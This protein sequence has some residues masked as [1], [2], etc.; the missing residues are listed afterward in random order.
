MGK[1]GTP[2]IEVTEYFMSV[3]F[4]IC[5]QADA[6][7]ALTVKEKSAWFGR[8]EGEGSITISQSELFGGL[9]K[10]GGLRGTAYYLPGGDS[11]VLPNNLAQKLGRA[12]GADCP[13]YRGLA[14]IFFYGSSP[15][16]FYWTANTPYLPGVW[17]KVERAPVGLNPDYALIPTGG[18][19][20]A[21]SVATKEELAEQSTTGETI[22]AASMTFTP[23]PETDYLFLWSADVQTNSTSSPCGLDVSIDGSSIFTNRPYN[24]Q[25]EVVSPIDYVTMGGMFRYQSGSSPASTAFATTAFRHTNAAT[26]K[27]RNSRLSYFA[28]PDVYEYAESLAR[29]NWVN[30]DNKTAQTAATLNFTPDSTGDYT[31]IA[32]FHV[33]MTI[34]TNLTYAVELTDGSTTTGE[35]ECRPLETDNREPMM[36]VLPLGDVS[37]STTISLK[38]RQTNTG[39]TTIGISEIRI[40]A[41]RNDEFGEVHVTRTIADN[42][43]SE[44]TYTDVTSQTFTPGSGSYLTLAC[45]AFGCGDSNSTSN[46]VQLVD[47]GTTVN[48]CIREFLSL[49][50]NEGLGAACHRISSFPNSERTQ[51]IQRKSESGNTVTVQ[52]SAAILALR[53]SA[54]PGTGVDANPAHMIYECLTNVD[55][56]MGSPAAAIDYDSFDVASITLYEEGLGLSMI[57][58]RQASIQDFIQEILDHIQAVLY[59]DPATGLLTLA[60][61][62]GDY[63]ADLLDTLTPDNA[64]LTSF[65][66]KLWGDI[67]NEIVVTWT[68]P[69]NEQDET[70]SV[71][72]D[73]SIAI[74]GGSII[75]DSRNYYGVR[76]AALAQQLAMRD[77]RSAGQPLAAIEAEVDRSEWDLRPAS[78]IKVTW[79]EYSLD[80][81]VMRVQSVDYGKP[82][83]PTIK[84]SL[85]EDVFGLDIGAYDDP[86]SSSWV[87][88]SADPEPFD[89]PVIFTLPYFFAL[90]TTV[91]AFVESPEY[92]EVIAGVLATTDNTDAFAYEIWDE[93]ALPNGSTE[94]QSIT[95]NNIIGKGELAADLAAAAASASV[96]FA[97]IIGKTLPTV[98]GFV[99]IGD[100][101]EATSEIAMIDA[102][103]GDYDLVRGVL[104]TVPRDWPA[105]TPVWFVDGETLFEDTEIRAAGETVDYKLLMR[106]S[107]GLLSLGAAP[108]ESYT[109]TERPWLP[110]RPANVTAYGES[111]S[112]GANII[113]ALTRPDPWIT[114]TWAIRNRL[115]EDSLILA[116]DDASGTAEAGQTTT[117]EVRA[118]D[119]TLLTTHDGLT[120]TSFDVPDA[121]FSGEPIVRLRVY[122]ERSDADG[123]FVSLQYFEHWVQVGALTF[124]RTTVT[125]DNTSITMDQG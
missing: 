18:S 105:G 89:D 24:K 83:D 85:V 37:G 31:I 98:A 58:T 51:S 82:G 23:S 35:V 86:P 77:L 99:I 70:I 116:W 26:L 10:E 106:T 6:I 104:D 78:V 1:G 7:T 68:N 96:S 87:D 28:L 21:A 5:A 45:W 33:D 112:S 40:L 46:Y 22:D 32:S 47:D 29:Q 71:Q 3:H 62:R 48:E 64:D 25:R 73:S 69:E 90:G 119:G 81:L 44:S 123:D 103:D 79:P 113:D 53:V 41:L 88:P 95:T 84:L 107:Q 49:R 34:G 59:V 43:G 11:Q 121:S 111:W 92:P 76:S 93:V 74:Q 67:V 4:G 124:D 91:A 66:R 125:M 39:S 2:K 65:S 16:G 30:P 57:W 14:S 100:G 19:V 108:L 75:S 101:V 122:S 120:G 61:I 63:N 27:V 60:L 52:Q 80:Q 50:A 97:N 110:N 36:L 55:W 117:I 72:D 54:T 17:A 9:K 94:W 13:G 114:V 118:A 56:G 12:S 42:A 115:D 109:L 15:A 38:V 20:I 102:D 8:Q